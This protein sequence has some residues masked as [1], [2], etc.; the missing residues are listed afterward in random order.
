MKIN[1]ET[2]AVIKKELP[3]IGDFLPK[4]TNTFKVQ[5]IDLDLL[6]LTPKGYY[7]SNG[8]RARGR[9]LLID[10]DG[11]LAGEVSKKKGLVS[12]SQLCLRWPFVK[13]TEVIQDIKFRE[14]VEDA[15][16]RLGK[17]TDGV[18]YV[19]EIKDLGLDWDPA[20]VTLHKLPKKIST[21]R[22]WIDLKAIELRD[23]LHAKLAEA[24]AG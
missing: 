23:E 2:L 13:H 20:T 11:H 15:I 10:G 12:E 17:L 9:V 5:I 19:M 4:F 14:T 8:W 3:W 1:N 24:D 7:N 18:R 22:Y 16:R 6:S 21:L